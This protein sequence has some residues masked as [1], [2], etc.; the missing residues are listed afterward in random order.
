MKR[1]QIDEIKKFKNGNKTIG[2]PMTP[3][4]WVSKKPEL[5]P[6][7]DIH[8]SCGG[9]MGG[10][11]WHEYVK[12]I[13]LDDLFANECIK[14][15]TYEGEEKILNKSYIVRANNNYTV[16][17]GQLRSQNPNFEMGLY[18]CFWRVTNEDA[19][20]VRFVDEYGG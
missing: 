12:R 5:I 2:K 15:E 11:S 3:S 10:S 17:H 13:E 8:M 14:V 4:I 9:G 1:D 19:T 20:E 6:I 16:I 7:T 18:D